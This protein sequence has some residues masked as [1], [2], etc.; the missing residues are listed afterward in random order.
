M[1][2]KN[3]KNSFRV[4]KN[5]FSSQLYFKWKY[6]G[7]IFSCLEINSY[8]AVLWEFIV[9]CKASVSNGVPV[10]SFVITLW[11]LTLPQEHAHTCLTHLLLTVKWGHFTDRVKMVHICTYALLKW[12]EVDS[13]ESLDHDAGIGQGRSGDSEQPRIIPS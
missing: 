3:K 1:N 7:I 2:R 12:T 13:G 4:R 10:T 6:F 11:P 9:I 8:F 5:R